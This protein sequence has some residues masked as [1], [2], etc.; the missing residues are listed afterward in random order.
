MM[1]LHGGPAATGA[2]PGMRKSSKISA[3]RITAA[4][5]HGFSTPP[6]RRELAKADRKE[7]I[8]AAAR[9]L[10]RETGDSGLSMRTLAE[11]SGV[12]LATPYNL[13][14]SKRAILLALLEDVHDFNERFQHNPRTNA[15]E[16]IFEALH[17]A[18]E[19][20]RKDPRLYRALWSAVLDAGGEDAREAIVSLHS[21]E[22]WEALLGTA[23]RQGVLREE[24]AVKPLRRSLDLVY[25]GAMSHWIYGGVSNQELEPLVSYGYAL[26]LRGAAN[27]SS[28]GALDRRIAD[29]QKM[30]RR[31]SRRKPP[32][33]TPG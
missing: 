17:L 24:I 3:A 6:G 29:F 2:G 27:A 12:S 16:R 11:R 25:V 14:G 22:F 5:T 7:R 20:C 30:L 26:V 1:T 21:N 28:H 19:Y 9:A 10:I 15:L 8:V 33:R 13:F 18:L 4:G 23:I 32:A 31:G